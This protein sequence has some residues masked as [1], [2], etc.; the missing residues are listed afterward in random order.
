[1]SVNQFSA[2]EL[3]NIAIVYVTKVYGSPASDSGKKLLP[4]VVKALAQFSSENTIACN[5]NTPTDYPLEKAVTKEE[6]TTAFPHQGN[7]H[8]AELSVSTMRYNLV[9]NNGISYASNDTLNWIITFL[10]IFL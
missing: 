7:A 1:M 10:L 8:F 9:D 5:A 6:I 4:N 2:T 3:A